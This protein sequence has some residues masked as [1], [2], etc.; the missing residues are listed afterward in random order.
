MCASDSGSPDQWKAS[1]KKAVLKGHSMAAPGVD[2]ASQRHMLGGGMRA[3]HGACAL[4]EQ[5]DRSIFRF[6]CS[7]CVLQ[8][9]TWSESASD[10]ST[11]SSIADRAA[12][13]DS[14][15]CLE[16]AD[17]VTVAMKM[18]KSAMRGVRAPAMV[19]I[20]H[21]DG[22]RWPT[23]ACEIFRPCTR[24]VC[25]IENGSFERLL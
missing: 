11:A 15:T 5:P 10:R 2:R 13:R 23:L 18:A 8:Q 4:D 1:R 16:H 24:S 21:G 14:C 9:P 7:Q 22:G 25:P 6:A 20:L 12:G 19:M 3:P 17:R